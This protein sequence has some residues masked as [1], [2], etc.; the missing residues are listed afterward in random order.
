MHLSDLE[1]LTSTVTVFLVLWLSLNLTLPPLNKM[2]TLYLFRESEN[3]HLIVESWFNQVQPRY[4]SQNMKNRHDDVTK[5]SLVYL[6]FCQWCSP[7][8]LDYIYLIGCLATVTILILISN[9]FIFT[10]HTIHWYRLRKLVAKA[11]GTWT[12][13]IHIHV[14]LQGECMIWFE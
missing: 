11:F 2:F 3:K 4:W 9:L 8:P 6:I 14:A 13:N 5:L 1:T 10:W 12:E 7:R